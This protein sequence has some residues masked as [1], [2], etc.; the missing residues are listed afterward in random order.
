MRE[1]AG[2]RIL[3]GMRTTTMNAST[4]TDTPMDRDR[5]GGLLAWQFRNYAA[6]HVDR[7]N[8][9][10]H[11]ATAPLFY[12]GTIALAGA[13]PVGLLGPALAAVSL[14]VAGVFAMAAAV[15]VQ[16]RGHAREPRRPAPF[17]G[18]IDV[19]VRIFCEQWI[20]FPRFVV[21]GGFSR[22]WAGGAE[23]VRSEP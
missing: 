2:R 23:T 13:A 4:N 1:A 9:A 19:I 14:A 20:T 15:V 17:R 11:A 18:P 22:A 12:A 10:L 6:A 5:E 8:L 16:G 7:R 3:P 21:T